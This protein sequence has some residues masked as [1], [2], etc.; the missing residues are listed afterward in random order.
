MNIGGTIFK[1]WKKRYAVLYKD[2]EMAIY[3]T[4]NQATADTR[5]HLKA[6]CKKINIGFACGAM[7]LPKGQSN[8][9][10]LFCI[11]TRSGKEYFFAAASDR[12]CRFV[13]L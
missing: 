11:V 10:S 2:G 1:S 8:V 13:I 5:I 9:D 3:E 12:E 4:P 7:N 6:D